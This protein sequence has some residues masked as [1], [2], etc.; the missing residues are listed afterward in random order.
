MR[1]Y[2]D[3]DVELL[4]D[5][6]LG[7]F[8]KGAKTARATVRFGLHIFNCD[9]VRQDKSATIRI[10]CGAAALAEDPKEYIARE[11]RV[12]LKEVGL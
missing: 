10:D 5:V 2:S 8:F 4:T 6:L 11:V 3:A 12:A 9:N 1:G 7:Q